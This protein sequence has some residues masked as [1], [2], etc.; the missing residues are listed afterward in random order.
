MKYGKG[1]RERR[2]CVRHYSKGTFACQC[3]GMAFFKTLELHHVEENGN[4]RRKQVGKERPID[5]WDPLKITLLPGT[6]L[7]AYYQDIINRGFEDIMMVLCANCHK[8][9]ERWRHRGI[10]YCYIHHKEMRIEYQG[11]QFDEHFNPPLWEEPA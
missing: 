2:E 7:N 9:S 1:D 3:C 4:I 5:S 11:N 6:E 8:A 10:V